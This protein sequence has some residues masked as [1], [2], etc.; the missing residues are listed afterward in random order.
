[1]ADTSS[2]TM[3]QLLPLYLACYALWL[4]LAALGVW[5]IFAL[6]PVVFGLTIWL[7]LN[8]WQVRAV[9]NFSFVTFGLIWLVGILLL[10]HSLRQ[11][12]EKR[13]L[14]HRAARVFVAEAAA[15]GLCYGLQLLL[16]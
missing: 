2:R 9:D 5:L 15:L 8:P 7:R 6:R 3:R 16:A 13:R 11:G 12:V 14:W 4:A 1:M 10:E